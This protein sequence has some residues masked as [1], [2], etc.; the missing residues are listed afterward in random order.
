MAAFRFALTSSLALASA[1]DHAGTIEATCHFTATSQVVEG[2][3]IT[4]VRERAN[5][6]PY[7]AFP[8]PA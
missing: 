1:Q 7:T 6:K 4:S 5:N 3:G 2:G 8:L